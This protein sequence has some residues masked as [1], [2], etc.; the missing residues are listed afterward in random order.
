MYTYTAIRKLYYEHFN[1]HYWNQKNRKL[2]KKILTRQLEKCA[3]NVLI[4]IIGIRK[5]RKLLQ[6]FILTRELENC[7]INVLIHI[8]GIRQLE[9]YYKNV[10]LHFLEIGKLENCATKILTMGIKKLDGVCVC[11]SDETLFQKF[12]DVLN[13][14]LKVV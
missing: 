10:Y 2:Q 13:I 1:S 3:I 7:T 4:D 8:I 14:K 5:I 6:K 9:N 12:F 11:E